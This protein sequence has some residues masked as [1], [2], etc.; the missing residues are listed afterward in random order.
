MDKTVTAIILNWN[1]MSFIPECLESLLK[2]DYPNLCVTFVDNGST[3]GSQDYVQRHFP[4]VKTIYLKKNH[5]FDIPNNI[6]MKEAIASGANYL[7]LLNND[8]VLESDAISKLICAGERNP[9]IGALGPVQL[10]YG[11]S[12]QVVSA[13][14]YF[15]WKRGIVVQHEKKP[16]INKEV[17]FLS[18]AA[19]MLKV[20]V[21]RQVGILDQE[22]YFY[23]EDV[24]LCTRIV[25]KGYKLVCV[26][27]SIV[28]HHVRGSTAKSP[29]HTYHITRTRWMLMRKHA[30]ISAWLYFIPFYVKN[31]IL[32]EYLWNRRHNHHDENR[33]M[34]QAIWDSFQNRVRADY[35]EPTPNMPLTVKNQ[36]NFAPI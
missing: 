23:G 18:G 29:F 27:S 5:G 35:L 26:A 24:D 2:Q 30:N 22:Y 34:M 8:V 32:G 28:K 31:S 16:L 1:G 9:T 11:D 10:K 13:G 15:D 17:T 25:K 19:L 21:I 33:A 12:T 6:A 20:N 4:T 14:G 3:D 7:F 36:D